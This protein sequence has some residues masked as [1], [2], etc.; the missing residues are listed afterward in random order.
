M[1]TPTLLS[2]YAQFPPVNMGRQ[3]GILSI[4]ILVILLTGSVSSCMSS[5]PGFGPGESE[6]RD[7][8][9]GGDIFG[10]G[11]APDYGFE[12]FQHDGFGF[13]FGE[14][15]SH[16]EYEAPGH[17]RRGRQEPHKDRRRYK[18]QGHDG[19]YEGP[20]YEDEEGEGED[21]KKV[22]ILHNRKKNFDYGF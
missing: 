10:Y 8:D 17:D 20:E 15:F 21:Y 9:H 2:P 13:D 14:G 11:D 6:N 16:D 3:S 1:Q 19:G 7:G 5:I 22:L 4:S 18:D 12:G